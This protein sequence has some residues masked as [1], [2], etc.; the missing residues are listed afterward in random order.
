MSRVTLHLLIGQAS[1]YFFC[2]HYA[3]FCVVSAMLHA[4]LTSLHESLSLLVTP[5]FLIR[6]PIN[7][8]KSY[9]FLF[10]P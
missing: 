3:T 1:R 4:F 9:L 5:H 10:Y 8:S 6:H 7:V 2:L